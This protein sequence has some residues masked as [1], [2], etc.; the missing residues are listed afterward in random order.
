MSGVLPVFP[1]IVPKMEDP[2]RRALEDSS[3]TE[4]ELPHSPDGSEKPTNQQSL[5]SLTGSGT[6]LGDDPD[7]VTWDGPHDKDNP[8]NF[9]LARKLLITA[10]WI[11][12]CLVTCIASSIF[13]SAHEAIVTEF[14]ASPTVA[15]LGVS[16]FL[17]GYTVAPPLWGPLS[18]RFGRRWPMLL[19]TLLFTIFCVP[20]AVADNLET[21]L[22]GRFLQAAGGSAAMSL[23][24]G[25]LVDIWSPEQRGLAVVGM[26]S[27]VF[28]SP[29]V[30]PVMGNFV[31]ASHLG[32][33][34]TQWISCIMGGSCTVLVLFCLPETLPPLI[35]QSR[36]AKMRREGNPNARSEFDG[37]QKGIKALVQVYLLRP[38]GWWPPIFSRVYLIRW[39]LFDPMRSCPAANK[40]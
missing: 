15:T 23:A 25:G 7:L 35:L 29:I 27:A 17:L 3:A 26:V 18:E 10:I 8:Q 38:F 1:R 39:P 13:S 2:E 21:V 19:G 40:M 14:N 32:W 11:Y 4:A 33:R 9:S 30:A 31:A 36:A 12:G 22:V 5:R 16:L 28:G 37:T 20:V 6:Q 24:G 34:W